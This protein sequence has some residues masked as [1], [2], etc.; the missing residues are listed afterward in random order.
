MISEEAFSGVA[1][2]AYYLKSIHEHLPPRYR[3]HFCTNLF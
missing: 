2:E 1:A 3:F